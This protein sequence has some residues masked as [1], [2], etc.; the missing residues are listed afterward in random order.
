[1]KENLDYSVSKLISTVL[2]IIES[3]LRQKKPNVKVAIA[4]I[5][6]IREICNTS[7]KENDEPTSRI[8]TNFRHVHHYTYN[9]LYQCGFKITSIR[10]IDSHLTNVHDHP[11]PKRDYNH[12]IY[13]EI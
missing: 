3:P 8:G 4:E 7:F 12:P 5:S 1:L 10:E 11:D 6:R 13:N 2:E 9:C